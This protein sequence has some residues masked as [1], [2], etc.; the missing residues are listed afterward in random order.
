MNAIY[1]HLL[2]INIDVRLACLD[3]DTERYSWSRIKTLNYESS[4]QMVRMVNILRCRRLGTFFLTS[5]SQSIY[6]QIKFRQEW[7]SDDTTLLIIELKSFMYFNKIKTIEKHSNILY[8][9]LLWN[10]T[11]Y[12]L[13]A[14]L[15]SISSFQLFFSMEILKSLCKVR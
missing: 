1:I 3:D 6:N 5:L 12:R 10:T 11:M 14:D 8:R 13:L 15:T 9:F 4:T 2:L 7:I